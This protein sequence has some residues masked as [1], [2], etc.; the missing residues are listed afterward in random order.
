V[1]VRIIA[2]TNRNLEEEV[3][4]GR[5]RADLFYRLNILPL[6]MPALRERPD[7]IPALVMYFLSRFSRKFQKRIEAV[8]RET[9]D[10]LVNHAWP[11]NVRE[12]QNV[13]ERAVI[14]SQGPVLVLGPDFLPVVDSGIRRRPHRESRSAEPGDLPTLE[15]VEKQ[16]IMTAL[17]KT[18]GVIEGPK[19]AAKILAMHP[20]TL[21]SRMKKMGIQASSQKVSWNPKALDKGS[22][23]P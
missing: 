5:F 9:M 15:D 6:T 10:V 2:A 20:N 17:A 22:S 12:L 4:A 19:G 1:D 13:I 21:R 8:S 3:R 11:G 16:H 14:L 7:D 23:G 18:R